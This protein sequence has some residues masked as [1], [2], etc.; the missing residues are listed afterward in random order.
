M[1]YKDGTVIEKME[2]K[3]FEKLTKFNIPI[4]FIITK[5]PYVIH[6]ESTNPKHTKKEKKKQ[7]R[8]DRRK[9]IK[10]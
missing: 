1:E 6:N 3:L 4:I 9:E 8:Q 5:T 7:R 2:Y 10:W